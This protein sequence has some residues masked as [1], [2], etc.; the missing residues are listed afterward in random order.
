GVLSVDVGCVRLT[1]KFLHHDPPRP[2]ELAAALQVL[3]SHLDDVARE[4]PGAT[5]VNR[6]VGLAGTV[7][8]V[9][10]LDLGL[11][12]YDADLIHHYPLR[13]E[14]AEEIFRELATETLDERLAEP[15]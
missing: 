15:G 11:R 14:A 13:K 10:A 7:T 6:F 9:A 3:E 8:T 12:T 5:E 2:E 4:L 1:E